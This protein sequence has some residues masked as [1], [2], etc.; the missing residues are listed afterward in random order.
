MASRLVSK[1]ILI[2]VIY[3][4]LLACL[5]S[6]GDARYVCQGKCED[7]PNCDASCRQWGYQGGRC[8]EPLYQYCCCIE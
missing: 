5:S 3:A 4:I 1:C 6:F 7:L 8:L 2:V